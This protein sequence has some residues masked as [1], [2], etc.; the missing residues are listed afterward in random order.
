MRK[1]IVTAVAATALAVPALAS[2]DAPDSTF[3][4]K[5][6]AKVHTNAVADGSAKIT[7]NGQWVGGHNTY[8]EAGLDQTNP[9][10]YWWTD[11]TS[12][13]ARAATTSR[14]FSPPTVTAAPP[15]SK[16]TEGG[17]RRPGERADLARLRHGPPSVGRVSH[18]GERHP[19]GF[20]ARAP[21]AERQSRRPARPKEQQQVFSKIKQ[22]R[23]MTWV[24]VIWCVGITAWM[25]G[26]AASAQ[27]KRRLYLGK[28]FPDGKALPG[29]DRRRHRPGVAAVG[30][31]GF[32]GFVAL[33]LVWFM[34]RPKSE[35]AVA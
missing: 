4:P 15:R 31:F 27:S 25:I 19:P 32:F 21:P 2:A 3:V 20:E 26:G 30:V 6:N 11:Q 16:R 10:D 1:L 23:K 28:N 13:P 8:T 22:W 29:R 5:E 33:S 24:L 34:T 7:Q 18:W 35:L 12:A 9:T 14:R 17:R